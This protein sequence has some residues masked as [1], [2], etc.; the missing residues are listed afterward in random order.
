MQPLLIGTYT[1]GT[2]ASGIYFVSEQGAVSCAGE[3][4]N[5]SFLA[6]H[7]ELNVVY[8]CNEVTDYQATDLPDSV[9]GALSA[10]KITSDGAHLELLNQQPS[11]GADPC[12]I[13][14]DPNG[15][16]C[17][18]A[19]Y[20]GGT[21]AT[22][23]L[24]ENGYLESFQSLTEH[25]GQGPNPER[26]TSA[27]VHSS[28][29]THDSNLFVADLGAD[30][31]SRYAITAT[32]DIAMERTHITCAPGAGPRYMVATAQQLFVLNELNNTL[33]RYKLADLSLQQVISIVPDTTVTNL[34]AHLELSPDHKFL[35]LSN[36]GFDTLS[37]YEIE[38]Q[39]KHLQ[40]ISSG[41]QH[42]RHFALLDEGDRLVVANQHSDNLVF[43]DRDA[44]SGL[45][46]ES[47]MSIRVPA[48]SCVLPLPELR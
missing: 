42:P 36:R 39:L 27:H 24:D 5:P 7:P 45:L 48:P 38:P 33:S 3:T 16:F 14:M 22:F 25:S 41:G 40:T 6:I 2:D 9:T 29:I 21:F 18:V 44:G 35:Y 46:T 19:N 26:Q 47:S 31:V 23:P 37:V 28:L 20:T 43:F 32:G 13:T 10:F 12:H 11:M 8:C 34:A 17:V 4:D 1:R 30:V 15:Q